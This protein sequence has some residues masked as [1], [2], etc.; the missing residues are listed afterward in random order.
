MIGPIAKIMFPII[1]ILF[2][3]MVYVQVKEW[4]RLRSGCGE[5]TWKYHE[6]NSPN[7]PQVRWCNKCEIR[8]VRLSDAYS[9]GEE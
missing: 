8:Q 7:H 9:W 4:L 6:W 2:F 1:G 5:H 3:L